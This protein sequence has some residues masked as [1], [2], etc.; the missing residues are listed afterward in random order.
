MRSSGWFIVAVCGCA[1]AQHTALPAPVRATELSDS[2]C[3]F[4]GETRLMNPAADGSVAVSARHPLLSYGGRVDCN[5]EDGPTWGFVGASVRVR[6]YGRGLAVRLKDYGGG[7]PQTTNFYD[8]SVDGG[9]PR[10]LEVSPSRE[11]YDLAAGLPEGE[12]EV[13]LFKRVEAA[14]NGSRGAGKAQLLGFSLRGTRL[15]PVQRPQRR[16]EFIGDSI[17]CGY[18]NE[19]TTEHPEAA[20]YT[21]RNSNG[22]AAYGAISARQL[23]A[24]YLA[25]AYSGRGLSRN[26]AGGPGELLPQM[27]LSSVPEDPAA[28]AW[29]PSQYVPDAVV[30]NLGTNDFSTP[31]VDREAFMQ[32]Y[33][34]FLATLREYY[35]RAALVAAIGPML[36]DFYPPGAEGW[37]HAQADVRSA[38]ATRQAAGDSN[39]HL[40]TFEPQTGPWGEDFH[41]T[42]ATHLKMASQLAAMLEKTLGWS[43]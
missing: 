12:H 30:I 14:P 36:S 38:V 32:S 3:A 33:T 19:L 5:G 22:H 16:L 2:V 35:P 7:T 39:V 6:F 29:V 24:Q 25:V 43:G 4:A 31:G 27:Y 40:V 13:E 18:G 34:R 17:T 20:H 10:L 8:V 28:T 21:T 15:L 26:F 37:T 11:A 41:P 42:A 1:P 23:N 9:V